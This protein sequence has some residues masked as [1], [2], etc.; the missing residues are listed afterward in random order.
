MEEEVEVKQL[1]RYAHHDRGRVNDVNDALNAL[2]DKKYCNDRRELD[3]LDEYT[4]YEEIDFFDNNG[5]WF[6]SW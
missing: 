2:E 4:S 5:E 6:D 3:Y 1:D